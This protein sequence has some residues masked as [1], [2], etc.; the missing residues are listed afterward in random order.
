[1]KRYSLIEEGHCDGSQSSESRYI[2]REFIPLKQFIN[3]K[4][5]PII[6]IEWTHKRKNSH[7]ISMIR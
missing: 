3:K 5:S 6:I 2:T 4:R 1:M 7:Y